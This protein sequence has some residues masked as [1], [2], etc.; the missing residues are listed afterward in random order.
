MSEGGVPSGRNGTGG[1]E[2]GGV[3]RPSTSDWHDI[4]VSALA[5][6]DLSHDSLSHTSDPGSLMSLGNEGFDDVTNMYSKLEMMMTAVRQEV[7]GLESMKSKLKDVGKLKEK[8]SSTRQKLKCSEE[9]VEE[10]KKKLNESEHRCAQFRDDMQRLNDIYNDER[11]RHAESKSLY[12]KQEQALM[13]AQSELITIQ[14]EV[15]VSTE[16]KITIKSLKQQL[17]KC[18]ENSDNEK[19]EWLKKVFTLEQ[20]LKD[21]EK[22]KTELGNHVW[23]LTEELK[24]VKG[25]RE[26]SET[27][28][29][30]VEQ[31]LQE[32]ARREEVLKEKVKLSSLLLSHLLSPL[33]TPLLS[34]GKGAAKG[35]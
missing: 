4:A 33:L 29:K 35:S 15:Q 1:G 31:E 19:T 11:N 32:M 3:A 7:S 34:E 22:V 24:V 12:S 5:P 14:K 23:N 21:G 17:V 26:E 30:K 10:M 28:H 20:E 13:H 27:S 25:E 18:Q 8:L 16:Q 2:L 9:V 6:L